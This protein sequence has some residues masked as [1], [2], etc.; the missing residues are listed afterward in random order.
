MNC[1]HGNDGESD[2]M[3]KVYVRGNG[4]IAVRTTVRQI[5]EAFK[6]APQTLW[7]ATVKYTDEWRGVPTN[8]FLHACT[9]KRK[10]FEHEKETRIIWCDADAKCSRRAGKPIRCDLGT[11]LEKV[12]LAPGQGRWFRQV[13]ESVLRK[14]DIETE[15]ISSDLDSR[16][17][18]GLPSLNTEIN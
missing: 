6:D 16:P 10:C 3:W 5:Y 2:A 1:W 11:L 9:T 8:P 13:V 18:W 17:S 12:Y 4:G 15:I 7:I 14:Y